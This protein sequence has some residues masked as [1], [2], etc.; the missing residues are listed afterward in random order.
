MYKLGK[1]ILLNSLYYLLGKNSKLSIKIKLL[2]YKTLLMPIWT[3]ESTAFKYR[4]QPKNQIYIKKSNFSYNYIYPIL[5]LK[6]HTFTK[7]KIVP[8]T[9]E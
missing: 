1:L 7:L 9:I 3:N 8:T 6:L 4:R 2:F 5:N